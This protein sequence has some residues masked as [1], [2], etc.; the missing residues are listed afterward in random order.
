MG[1]QALICTGGVRAATRAV[2]GSG[3]IPGVP[4]LGIP[5]LQMTDS[6]EGV[7]GAGV[8]G[9]LRYRVAFGGSDGGRMGSG[10]L[11]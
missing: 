8:K 9:P 3:F 7:S 5:D 4:R 1:W 6:V 11:V 10:P 2:S